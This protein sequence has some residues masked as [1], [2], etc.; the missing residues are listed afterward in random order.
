MRTD[1]PSTSVRLPMNMIQPAVGSPTTSLRRA[2]LSRVYTYS[3][4]SKLLRAKRFSWLDAQPA[5]GGPDR[6]GQS[7]G[8]HDSRNE[9]EYGQQLAHRASGQLEHAQETDQA[10]RDAGTDL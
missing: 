8:C 1:V 3:R 2:R 7:H 9:T 6:R 5:T 10:H 4:R